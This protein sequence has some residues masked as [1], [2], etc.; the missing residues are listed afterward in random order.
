MNVLSSLKDD[1]GD[2]KKALP[3]IEIV[4]NPALRERHWVEIKAVLGMKGDHSSLNLSEL[5]RMQARD[6][7]SLAE[8]AEI[9]D[10]A[11]REVRLERMI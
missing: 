6:S 9:S 2:L 5:R 4:C 11:R 3:L 1:L 10:R 7:W 8:L